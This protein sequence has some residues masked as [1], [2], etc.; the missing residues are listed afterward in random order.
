MSHSETFKP[1]CPVRPTE[2]KMR[3]QIETDLT[4][5][6]NRRSVRHFSSDPIPLDVVEKAI[7][8]AS[9]APSGAHKQPWTFCLVTNKDLQRSIRVAAEKEE[10]Q[11]YAGRMSDEWLSDL[12]PL[13]TNA[14]KPFLEEAPALIVMFKQTYGLKNQERSLHYYVNESVGIAA[15]FLISALHRAGLST[16]THTPS[17]MNFLEQL[18]QRPANEKAYLLLPVGYAHADA[19]VPDLSRKPAEDYLVKYL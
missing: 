18:L 6:W 14:D 4:Q 1:Y 8:I 3:Q 17:P 13:G 12:K 15:G 11:N 2:D 9:S 19:L 10:C 7:A 5:I 16:L